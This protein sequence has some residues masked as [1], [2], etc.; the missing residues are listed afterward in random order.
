M[1]RTRGPLDKERGEFPVTFFV[2]VGFGSAAD[3]DLLAE[4]REVPGRSRTESKPNERPQKR[5]A[6]CS[7]F[8][9]AV[10]LGFF[11]GFTVFH[12][13]LAADFAA[14]FAYLENVLESQG[15][16]RKFAGDVAS[17]PIF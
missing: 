5:Q 12:A 2:P 17:T 10:S 11:F 15:M 1:S 13:D 3:A 16:R 7:S 8:W 14:R 9:A 4:L 6:L